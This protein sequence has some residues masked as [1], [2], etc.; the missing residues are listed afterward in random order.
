MS[1]SLYLGISLYL[2]ILLYL[3][4]SLYLGIFLYLDISLYLGISLSQYLSHSVYLSEWCYF[5]YPIISYIYTYARQRDIERERVKGIKRERVKGGG[6]EWEICPKHKIVTRKY[7]TKG[8]PSKY[9]NTRCVL[10]RYCVSKNPL[11]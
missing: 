10:K 5:I 2:D 8:L 6:I 9:E 1:L 11:M 7:Y 3:G 4:I